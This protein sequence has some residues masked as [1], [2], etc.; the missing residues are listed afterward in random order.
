[1]S[2]TITGMPGHL[3]RRCHQIAVAVF[4]EEC[5]RFDLTPLQYAV[6]QTLADSGPQDQVTLGGA[7]ALDRST[8]T[9][10]L[11][12]LEQR[13]LLQRS[14]SEQDGRAKIVSLT[15]AGMALLREVR[16][17][18]DAAQRRIVAPLTVEEAARLLQLLDKLAQGN[19]DLSR[20][21]ARVD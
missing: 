18:V 15:K 10:V 4:L 5:A 13:Y 9:V 1:M 11:R 14:Q 19:N 6:L 7:T 16:P 17:A 3:L 20:A 12:K 2:T 21:P 8:V